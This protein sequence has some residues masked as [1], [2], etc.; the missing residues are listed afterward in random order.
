[1]AAPR[2]SLEVRHVRA[3]EHERLRAI[4]LQALATDPAGF[5]ATYDRD[6]GQAA[7]WWRRWAEGSGAGDDQ[8]TFVLTDAQ[9]RWLGLALVRRDGNRPDAAVINAMWVAPEARGSGGS[10]ALCDAC[11]GWAAE[12][13]LD[14]ITLTVLADNPRARRAYE[15]AGFVVQGTTTWSRDDR[16]LVE[17][18]GGRPAGERTE[19]DRPELL[20][21][22]PLRA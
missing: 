4:R 9:D 15:A 13:G 8:R 19:D 20:M 5:T 7:A 22:R 12:R 2:P 21:S 14:A 1:M 6:A 16:T 11:A 18:I 10:R 17:F 3:G